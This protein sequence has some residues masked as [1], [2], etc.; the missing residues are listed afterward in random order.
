M[1]PRNPPQAP[2]SYRCWGHNSQGFVLHGSDS[3]ELPLKTFSSR[4]TVCKDSNHGKKTIL[5]GKSL[6]TR[7]GSCPDSTGT[8][9][10]WADA[11]R[12]PIGPDSS[13]LNCSHSGLESLAAPIERS[14]QQQ[15]IFCR[16]VNYWCWRSVAAVPETGS[17]PMSLPLVQYIDMYL[18][19]ICQ[20]FSG[21]WSIDSRVIWTA[22]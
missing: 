21:W 3:I 14:E 19:E 6:L 2:V 9:R 18:A 13:W 22:R 11:P 4:N 1:R 20:T 8:T 10:S 7:S 5:A 12:T 16:W 17:H 15:H